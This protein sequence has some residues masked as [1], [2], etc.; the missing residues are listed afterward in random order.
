MATLQNPD[1]WHPFMNSATFLVGSPL[2]ATL[3]NLVQ[4]PIK[5][6]FPVNL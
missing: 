4:K 3:Q 6:L 5:T 1:C 2:M